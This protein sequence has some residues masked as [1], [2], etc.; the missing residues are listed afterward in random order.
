MN[1]V[2]WTKFYNQSGRFHLKPHDAWKKLLK[3]FKSF[4]VKKVLDLGSGSGRHLIDLAERNFD[5]LGIDYSPAAV[6]LTQKWLQ[7]KKLGAK[8][9]IANIHETITYIEDASYDAVL[10]IN[11]IHYTNIDT[12]KTT[13]NEINRILETGGVLFLVIPSPKSILEGPDIEQLYLEKN[14]L[15]ELLKEKF[16]ILELSFDKNNHHVVIAQ[17]K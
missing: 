3:I 8:V 13:L 2:N 5:V 17:E 11:S 6:D 4:E 14:E 10:A 12:F 16:R 9:Q 1:R 7:A 15:K